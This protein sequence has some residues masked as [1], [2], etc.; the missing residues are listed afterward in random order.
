VSR[1]SPAAGR[2]LRF[3]ARTL[4]ADR[5]AVMAIVNRTP[6]SFYDRGA[7]YA[8]GAALDRVDQALDEGARWLDIGGVKAGP[9]PEVGEAEELDRVLPLV[10]AARARTDAVLSVDTWRPGVA[11][12][13]LAA[14]ADVINDSSG[15]WYPEIADVV[16]E[17]RAG[18]VVMHH[19]GPPRTPGHGHAYPGGDVVGAVRAF[20]AVKAAEAERRGV[21]RDRLIVDP[22]HDFH[23]NVLDSLEVTRRTAELTGLGCPLL[24]AVSNKDFIGKTLD[25]PRD[26]RL[27]GSIAAAVFSIL[28][29][30]NIVRVHDVG[31]TVRAVRMTEAILGWRQPAIPPG[32]PRSTPAQ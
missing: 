23:K 12:R 2:Q 22:G 5:A 13:A 19:V 24:V 25:R 28:A 6:D 1:M 18:L 27:E 4:P 29:G 17:A 14:G 15:L 30:A 31:A 9:G 26:G 20:L 32:T 7:T 11:R 16:A 10:E 21:G 8:L 3:G